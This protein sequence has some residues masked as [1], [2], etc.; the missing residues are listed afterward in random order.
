MDST[1]RVREWID[2]VGDTACALAVPK[3]EV[4]SLRYLELGQDDSRGGH[5]YWS[6]A[7]DTRRVSYS[8]SL[9]HVA[10][11]L[12]NPIRN[13]ASGLECRTYL[14]RRNDLATD[15]AAM[16]YENLEATNAL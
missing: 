15:T 6:L 7:L 10:R 11:C 16:K 5:T 3:H 12:G 9:V 4:V 13:P 8:E 2:S 14:D 1:H